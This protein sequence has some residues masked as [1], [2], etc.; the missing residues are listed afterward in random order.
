MN[1]Y[2]NNYKRNDNTNED[3]LANIGIRSKMTIAAEYGIVTEYSLQI[4]L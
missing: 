3:I 4:H 2:F 1:D